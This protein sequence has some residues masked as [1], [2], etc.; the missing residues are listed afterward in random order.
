VT[1]YRVRVV[2]R[3]GFDEWRQEAAGDATDE[4]FREALKTRMTATGETLLCWQGEGPASYVWMCPGCGGTYTGGLSSEPVSGWESP[5]WVNT[6][7]LERPNLSP[8]LGCPRW[9][10]GQCVGHWWMRDGEL[11]PA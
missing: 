2:D 11:V 6:G 9:R 10:D 8:S 7:T 4:G 5:R 3:A 1:T